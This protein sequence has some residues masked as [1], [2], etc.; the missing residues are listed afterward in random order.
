MVD[1][2]S[3]EILWQIRPIFRL[4]GLLKKSGAAL[5]CFINVI[6]NIRLPWKIKIVK[7]LFLPYNIIFLI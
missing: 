4:D 1:A 7:V 2:T 3:Y 5:P 6:P